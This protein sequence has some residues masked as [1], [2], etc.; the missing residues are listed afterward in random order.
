MVSSLGDRLIESGRVPDQLLR[1]GIRANL[2]TRLARERRK[3]LG[4]TRDFVERLRASPIAEQVE[5]A[6]EQHYEL[7]AEFFQLVLGH[8]SSTAPASGRD[9]VDT[10]AAGRGPRCSPSPASA[11]GSRTG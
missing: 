2:A 6:N 1:L 3:G 11:P 9:G 8:G 4:A 10:L 7:P 5:R